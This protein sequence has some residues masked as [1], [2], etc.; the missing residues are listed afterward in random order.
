MDVDVD[1]D[2]NA[3]I[4]WPTPQ[5]K[6]L[7]DC[8][9]QIWYIEATSSPKDMVILLDASGSMTGQRWQ[10]ARK[11]VDYILGSLSAND[12]FNVFLVRPHSARLDFSCCSAPTL[13]PLSS[14]YSS[15]SSCAQFNNQP[16]P[17]MPCFDETLVQGT[18]ENRGVCRV[19]LCHVTH[20]ML[21]L[22]LLHASRRR[23]IARV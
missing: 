8:R 17:L 13:A 9:H 22:L 18:A 11:T 4:K 1:V 6:D 12:F 7:Y 21:V 16:T 15:Y 2:V 3:G 10:I 23:A 5:D 14:S 20:Y 19:A